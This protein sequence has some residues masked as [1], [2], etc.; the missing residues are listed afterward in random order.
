MTPQEEIDFTTQWYAVRIRRIR[1]LI[2]EKAPE[3]NHELCAVLANETATSLEP[4]S[5][6][7]ILNGLR[8]KIAR[9]ESPNA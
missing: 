2:E 5:Y 3:L 6:S 4:P 9:L 8:H 7:Q 1:D